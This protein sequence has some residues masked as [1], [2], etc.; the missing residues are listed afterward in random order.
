MTDVKNVS[1]LSLKEFLNALKSIDG[2]LLNKDFDEKNFYF[3]SVATDSRSVKKNTLFVPLIGEKQDGHIYIP[4]ALESGA[5]VV[6][7]SKKDDEIIELSKKNPCVAFVYVSNTLHGLQKAAGAY[8][9]KFPN[10]IRCSVTGSSGK[11]TTKEIA[12]SVLSQKYKVVCNVGNLNS[13]TGLPLSV[14]SIR[15]DHELGLF[16]MGMNRQ[17]EIGE[18]AEVFK[19]NFGIITNIGTAHIGLLGSREAIAQEKKKIFN[20]VDSNGAAVIPDEDDFADFLCEGVKG[21]IIRYGK[22]VKDSG[23]VFISDDGLEGTTFSV[24][25]VKMRLSL[26][27]KYNF[28]NALGAVALARELGLSPEQ[29]KAGIESL[30][31]LSGRSQ[32]VKGRLNVLEDCYNANPDSMEKAIEF[33]A[34]VNIPSKKI[35]V[36]GDMLELGDESK[37]AHANAGKLAIESKPDMI[38]FVGTE[39]ASGFDEAKKLSGNGQNTKL[40]HVD[41]YSLQSIEKAASEINSF[42]SDGDFVLLKGSR[43]VGLERLM[44][45]LESNYKK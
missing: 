10:L 25:G 31:P 23:V 18:I 24:D 6:L 8:V 21:K 30:K 5:S 43:G 22:N 39:M 11:T 9:Q 17:N 44:P 28:T 3:D 1:F 38:V 15:S 2:E 40:I 37:K 4:K 45:L 29:I 33:C 20:F 7:V 13:E 36:L 16:E 34:S 42:A 32:L 12:A 27:G 41:D 26:P 14:F 35:F 19:P